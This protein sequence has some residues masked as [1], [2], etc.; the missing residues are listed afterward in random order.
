MR[1]YFKQFFTNSNAKSFYNTDKLIDTINEKWVTKNC[2]LCDTNDWTI[3]PDL[4]ELSKRNEDTVIP[5]AIITCNNCGNTI[6]IS[7]LAIKC[8]E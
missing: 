2:P 4:I 5:L 1:N 8:L 6:F 7:P 3:N